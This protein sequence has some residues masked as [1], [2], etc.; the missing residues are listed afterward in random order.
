MDGSWVVFALMVAAGVLGGVGNSLNAITIG[1]N[2]DGTNSP[3]ATLA[4][5]TVMGIIAAF[6]TPLFLSLAKSDIL[7]AIIAKYR[8]S[9]QLDSDAYVFFGFCLVAAFSSRL[10][11]RSLTEK[12][13]RLEEN[14][15]NLDSKAEELA[16]QQDAIEENVESLQEKA[17]PE[18]S[19][20]KAELHGPAHEPTPLEIRI[21]RAFMARPTL[22]RSIVG[23]RQDAN[24]PTA[25]TER[26]LQK[27]EIEEF[28]RS[29]T[30][31]KTGRAL[32]QITAAGR[33]ALEAALSATTDHSV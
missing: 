15:S 33:M 4:S 20:P 30:S 6:V 17:P 28:V 31:S 12:V 16:D 5:N 26:K 2:S 18:P 1:D 19:P 7:S 29:K 23:I 22:W 10:F 8:T 24:L 14:V 3:W 9:G 27:L 21:L 11:M 32:Y 25:I 13:L